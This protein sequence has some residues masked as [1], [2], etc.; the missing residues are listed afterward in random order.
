MK[1]NH[2]QCE[3][4]KVLTNNVDCLHKR[5]KPPLLFHLSILQ[6]Q[7]HSNQQPLAH[8][9]S[10]IQI[11]TKTFST[12]M[13][14]SKAI[15]ILSLLSTLTLATPISKTT[16]TEDPQP[17]STAILDTPLDASLTTRDLPEGQGRALN[18]WLNKQ[19]EN[20]DAQG[21]PK[22]ISRPQ[23]TD[24]QYDRHTRDI[25]DETPEENVLE[26][27]VIPT[28][29]KASDA[30]KDK[31]LE[32]FYKNIDALGHPISN[33]PPKPTGVQYDR[34][35]RDIEDET[36]DENVLDTRDIEDETPDEN[37]L[38]A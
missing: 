1:H 35:P 10:T 32:S 6:K 31:E 5:L 24:V 14:P 20:H 15:F 30:A 22:T 16:S 12:V 11:K 38:E 4:N 28:Q 25:E 18:E 27:R 33:S 21:Q 9:N 8:Q 19:R 17:T 23:P 37:V 2:E 7:T 34:H 29:T 36:P 13:H 26:A 3:T